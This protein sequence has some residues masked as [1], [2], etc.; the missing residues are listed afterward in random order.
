[1]RRFLL[2]SVI[3]LFLSFQPITEGKSS[4]EQPEIFGNGVVVQI[5]IIVKDI[6]KTSRAYADLLEV[7]MPEWFLT[8]NMDKAHTVFKGKLSEARAKLAFFQLKNI[9]IELIEPVG[10]PSTWQEFLDTK[11][12]G[13]H[14]IAFEIKGMD[15]KIIHLQRKGMSLLQRGDYEEGQY[16]YID[17]SAQLGVILELLENFSDN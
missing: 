13:V 4:D 9:T 8:D 12:E 7:D 15:G 6:E 10:G 2:F 17:G 11:G 16:S 3:I 5:G 1:M 14:H